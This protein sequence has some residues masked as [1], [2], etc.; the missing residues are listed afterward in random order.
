[1]PVIHLSGG[2][3]LSGSEPGL[4]RVAV[5]SGTA[6]VD[7]SLPAALPVA[8]LIPA[9]VESLGGRDIGAAPTRYQLCPLGAGALPP[10]QSLAQSGIRDGTVLALSRCSAEPA[11]GPH[12]DD[13]EAVLAT[14]R[15]STRPPSRRAKELTGAL[16][17]G[18]VG[19]VGAVLLVRDALG[20]TDRHGAAT[21]V[22]AITSGVL[23]LLVAGMTRR[24]GRE[25]TAVFTLNVIATTF[26][27]VGALLA[28]PGR[29]GVPNLM[30]AAMGA[31]VAAALAIRLTGCGGVTFTAVMCCAIVIAAAALCGVITGAA[32][33]VVG[34]LT[35]LA[36]LVALEVSARVSMVVAGLSPK[37]PAAPGSEEAPELAAPDLLATRAV[38]A[39]RWLNG[40]HGG[41]SSAAAL[42]A[43]V[44]VLGSQRA[45]G[46]TAVTGAVLL[47]RA[48]AQVDGRSRLM[49]LI[50]GYVAGTAA[51][52][53]A[54]PGLAQH[55]PWIAI[56]TAALTALALHLGFIAPTR[57]PSPIACRLIDALEFSASASLLPL[58][59]WTCGV[60][61]AVGGLGL[62]WT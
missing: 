12:D 16:T 2:P 8:E 3:M 17:A 13:A 25:P 42:G 51:F 49:F 45:I 43:V 5:H 21:A 28:V 54:A 24:T 44:A 48:R 41:F 35:T 39:D 1:M 6:V 9:I 53:V 11:P 57:P 14:L 7:L 4:C 58:A 15:G 30:L 33:Y 59:C 38:R 10:S 29:L 60:F 19:G 50:A 56:L 18:G 23:A 46:L 22:V 62:T 61:S 36:A 52:A 34:S 26:V 31:S 27:A 47:L 37:L 55:G 40:L 20:N 32:L